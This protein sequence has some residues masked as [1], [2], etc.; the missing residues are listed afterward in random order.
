METGSTPTDRQRLISRVAAA[1]RLKG[2]SKEYE[3][4]S[5]FVAECLDGHKVEGQMADRLGVESAGRWRRFVKEVVKA[6]GPSV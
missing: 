2:V 5:H 6:A 3:A 1:F 4:A